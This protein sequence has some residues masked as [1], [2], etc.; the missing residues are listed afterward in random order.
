MS[1]DLRRGDRESRWGSSVT[2]AC[3]FPQDRR[4]ARTTSST[5]AEE[6]TLFKKCGSHF[7]KSAFPGSPSTSTCA[8]VEHQTPECLALNPDGKVP[9]LLDEGAVICESTVVN[10]YLEDR[11][12]TPPLMPRD[13][14]GRAEVRLWEDYGDQAFLGP[15][16]GIFIHDKGWCTFEP[17]RLQQMR[18]HVQE[19]LARLE[20]HLEGKQFLVRDTFSL[21]DICFTPRIILLDQLGAPLP[22]SF[23]N[24]RA[25]IERLR[26]RESTQGLET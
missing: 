11:F 10:E 6:M 14:L 17:E 5:T 8:R 3:P 18:Q 12:P 2:A 9:V 7:P 21:A 19:V 24:T 15:A 1:C 13:P 20:K 4:A 16:E 26:E 22:P 25:W 23:G